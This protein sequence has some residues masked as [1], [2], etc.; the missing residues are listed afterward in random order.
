VTEFKAKTMARLTL[1]YSMPIPHTPSRFLACSG[2]AVDAR[3]VFAHRVLSMTTASK[4]TAMRPQFPW[5]Y[6]PTTWKIA[7]TTATS[8][9]VLSQRMAFARLS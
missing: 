8:A 6:V 5:C 3:R 9:N 2:W 4:S 1:A 7:R